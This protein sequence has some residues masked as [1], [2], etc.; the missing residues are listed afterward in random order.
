V[1]PA[2]NHIFTSGTGPLSPNEY[3]PVQH[4][5]REVIEDIAGWIDTVT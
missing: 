1:Y 3:E 2:R 5:D 4:V